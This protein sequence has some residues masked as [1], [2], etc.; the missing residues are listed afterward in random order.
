M[1]KLPPTLPVKIRYSDFSPTFFHSRGHTEAPK[2]LNWLK[3]YYYR[4]IIHEPQTARA[5]KG[6]T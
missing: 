6:I 2:V 3:V 5:R 4:Q 1:V